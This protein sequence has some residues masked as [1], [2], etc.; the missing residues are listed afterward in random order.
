MPPNRTENAPGG[1]FGG[2]ARDYL[3]HGFRMYFRA[4]KGAISEFRRLT[5]FPAYGWMGTNRD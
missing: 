4:I 1:S 2:L 5:L 3:S